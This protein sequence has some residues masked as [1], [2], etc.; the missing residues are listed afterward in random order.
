M[1]LFI[2]FLLVSV[3]S[4]TLVLNNG[5]GNVRTDKDATVDLDD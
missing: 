1:R 4:C 2:V 5:D 3:S